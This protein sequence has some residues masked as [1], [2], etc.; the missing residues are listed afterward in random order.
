MQTPAPRDAFIINGFIGGLVSACV[1]IVMLL[2]V[3]LAIVLIFIRRE[4][5]KKMET[6]VKFE[7]NACH[8][9]GD[10]GDVPGD[11]KY[12]TIRDYQNVANS[13]IQDTELP[14]IPIEDD[15]YAYVSDSD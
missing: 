10:G 4:K 15:S 12:Q 5:L 14:P 8:A 1:V 11:P 6:E 2:I 3:I 9:Y 7:L 13:R